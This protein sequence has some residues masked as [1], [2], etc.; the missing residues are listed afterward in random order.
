MTITVST[1]NYDRQTGMWYAV[2]RHPLPS[3]AHIHSHDLGNILPIRIHLIYHN[4][5]LKTLRNTR[6][7]VDSRFV[8]DSLS[9][10]FLF[11]LLVFAN[12]RHICLFHW[13]WAY[14]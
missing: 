9:T 4:S 3:H 13:F 8:C 11:Q 1:R 7:P 14:Q 10:P 2:V 12:G 5:S 6:T